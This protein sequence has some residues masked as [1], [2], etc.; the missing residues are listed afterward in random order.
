[1]LLKRSCV[2]LCYTGVMEYNAGIAICERD[3]EVLSYVAYVRVRKVLP[4]VLP[5]GRENCVSLFDQTKREQVRGSVVCT[6]DLKW[7]L[8]LVV[9]KDRP[10]STLLL[11]Q[12]DTRSGAIIQLPDLVQFPAPCGVTRSKFLK[13]LCR[14]RIFVSQISVCA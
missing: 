2:V 12:L 10:S 4:Y 7:R 3:I 9:P 8:F 6:S 5:Y 14:I 1:M 11:W 13:T